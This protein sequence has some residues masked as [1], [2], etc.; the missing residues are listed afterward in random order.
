MNSNFVCIL[1]AGLCSLLRRLAG[2]A[3]APPHLCRGC[4]QA[5]AQLIGGGAQLGALRLTA[6]QRLTHRPNL[7]GQ[8][9]TDGES[10]GG[11]EELGGQSTA[12]ALRSPIGQA[13]QQALSPTTCHPAFQLLTSPL[14]TSSERLA[15]LALVRAMLSSSCREFTCETTGNSMWGGLSKQGGKSKAI[16]A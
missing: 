7:Q 4:V 10:D 12:S 5:A 11:D 2:L 6:G 14:A 1:Q 3:F 16:P 8:R 15:P 9:G 13:A